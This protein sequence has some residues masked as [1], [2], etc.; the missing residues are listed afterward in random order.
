[1]RPR[2][3]V[4]PFRASATP[5][6]VAAYHDE[7][8]AYNAALAQSKPKGD[9]PPRTEA[10]DSEID[11][12][13]YAK[14]LGG[15]VSGGGISCPG[16]N[17]SAI[18]RSLSVRFNADGSFIVNSFAGD[19]PLE[20]RDHVR[21]CLEM[22]AW[23]PGMP[24]RGAPATKSPKVKERRLTE[25][26]VEK[27]RL[28]EALWRE[29]VDPRG[30]LAEQYLREQRALDLPADLCGP[31]LRFNPKCTWGAGI[32]VPALIALFRKIDDNRPTAILRIG[33]NSKAEKIERLML[34]PVGGAAVKLR[35]P[36][37]G[38]L[39]IAEGVETAMAA[40]Q[41]ELG[42]AW[43]LGTV[44]A[45]AKFPVVAGV[46]H[47]IIAEETGEPSRKAV[48]ECSQRWRMAGREVSI[49]R[50]EHGSDLN[51]EIILKDILAW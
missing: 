5:E 14:A 43:A 32:R 13:A 42:P 10:G 29:A 45:V 18:D 38:N 22:P 1:M 40:M 7:Q 33:L 16:P 50:P 20:C 11:L 49:A 3:P 4:A 6:A 37:H 41:L 26:E 44:G 30:T 27:R 17:H 15:G 9:M 51:D 25:A 28:A 19:D 46:D 31:V 48:A 36:Q 34:G 39:V 47:L 35:P 12:A 24:R 23:R 2:P 8:A 21:E